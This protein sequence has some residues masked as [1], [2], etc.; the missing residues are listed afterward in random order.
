MVVVVH[1]M[2]REARRTLH[3]LSRSYQW[4]IDDLDYEVIV[5]ENGSAPE[6]RLGDE[7]VRSFGPEFRYIDLGDDASPSPPARS[8]AASRLR[9]LPTWR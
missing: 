4:G 6:Q 7:L 8:T 3:S 1:N 9:R 2:H 5:V